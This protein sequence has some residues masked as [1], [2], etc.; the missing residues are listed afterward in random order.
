M[1]DPTSL[2]PV[3]YGG[4]SMVSRLRRVIVKRPSDAFVDRDHIT[5]QWQ[6]LGYTAPPELDAATREHG[7]LTALLQRLGAEV[8]FL[9]SDATCTLDS[10]YPHDPVLIS[11][12]GAIL[13][14]MGKSA[15]RAEVAAMARALEDWKVPTLGR[16]AGA[17]TAEGGD[18]VWLDTHTLLAGEG[19][20]TNAAG[21]A[22]LQVLLAPLEVEVI[23]VPLPYGSGPEA[24]LHLMSLI[25][26]L[27]DDLMVAHRPLLPVF[28]VRWLQARGIE[29]VDSAPQEL[30][31][32]ACNVLAVAP[33]EVVMLVGNSITEQRLRDIGCKVHVVHGDEIALK[34]SGGPTCLTRPLLRQ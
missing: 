21:I 28:I 19:F 30:S 2:K 27:D 9:P 24:C 17:A 16:L 32:Q 14:N 11:N 1:S 23:A 12:G 3:G 5:A 4:H 29:I 22:S 25:S 20:R 8:L 6:A 26:M 31:T 33:R 10:L 34:G 15:R 7:E 18:L 13:L